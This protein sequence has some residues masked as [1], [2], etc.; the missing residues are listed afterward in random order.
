MDKAVG[1]VGFV[2]EQLRWAFSAN[3][4]TPPL[5]GGTE[6]VRF[7]GGDSIPFAAW[8]SHASSCG[9]N[10]P[11]VWARVVRR[12]RSGGLPEERF[13]GP[14][15]G[16]VDPRAITVEAGVMRC[17]ITDPE[18]SWD[19]LEREAMVQL[20]DSYRLDVAL[21]RAMGCA[22]VEG[23][24]IS[25]LLAAGEPFGPEG[26]VLAWTQWIHAQLADG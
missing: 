5:G 14:N 3:Q 16:C 18:P 10:E 2:V 4:A 24:A 19:D 22:E 1:V 12:Y 7:F 20:D 23:M 6:H 25:T 17:A 21:C 9:C 26:G 15:A 8:N 13:G 11:L